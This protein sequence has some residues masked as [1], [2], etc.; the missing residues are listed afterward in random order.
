MAIN[1]VQGLMGA[2]KS[3]VMTNVWLADVLVRSN[4]P[5]Y[6][7]LPLARLDPKDPDSLFVIVAQLFRSEM[8]RQRAQARITLLRPM[9]LQPLGD[10]GEPL[11]YIPLD[12]EGEPIKDALPV[13]LAKKHQ[14]R[15]FWY[16]TKPNAAVFLDEVADIWSTE[17]RRD[18]PPEMKSYIRHHRHY[19]DDLW[20]AFQDKEDIDP[21]LRR[22]IQKLWVIQNSVRVN[23]FD[24]AW[25]R[26]MR[27]P[28]QFFMAKSYLGRSAVGKD[29]ASLS[30]LQPQ[31]SLWFWPKPAG[32]KVYYSFSQASKLAGKT[33]ATEDD[34]SS[35]MTKSWWPRVRDFF[36]NSAPLLSMI[37]GVGGAGVG[38][39]YAYGVLMA[40]LVQSSPIDT[41][42]P[43]GTNTVGNL[44]SANSTVASQDHTT[45]YPPA[46][47]PEKLIFSSRTHIHTNKRTMKKGDS[48][49]GKT[50]SDIGLD[51]V[52]FADGSAAG[53]TVLFQRD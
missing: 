23:M 21:D 15:E 53:W 52:R 7:N 33:S 14:Q 38:A 36:V 26:G 16:F 50:I 31:D 40:G 29:E 28:V 51:G 45:N 46:V 32:F 42:K 9:V 11:S 25:L 24:S 6:T 44:A 48:I 1:A 43:T 10:D 12:E 8:D 3:Y 49:N 18:R 34:E 2:G 39:Y 37:G 22:K 27:W 19:K 4:R 13:V 47:V 20:F 35:D 41:G 17:D 30:T 5:I